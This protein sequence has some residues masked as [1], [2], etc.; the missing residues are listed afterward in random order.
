MSQKYDFA[1]GVEV[2]LEIMDEEYEKVIKALQK[3]QEWK[4][5]TRLPALE[6]RA[7]LIELKRSRL[8]QHMKAGVPFGIISA[9][10]G[11]T[12][13][14]LE[15]V[16]EKTKRVLTQAL[17]AWNNKRTVSLAGDIRSAGYVGVPVIGYGQNVIVSLSEPPAETG[18]IIK[19]QGTARIGFVSKK[20]HSFVVLPGKELYKREGFTKEDY[21]RLHEHLEKWAKKYNQWGYVVYRGDEGK[22]YLYGAN[23]NADYKAIP[24]KDLG[25]NV[26][27]AYIL[28]P[29][30]GRCSYEVMTTWDYISF[31]PD[32]FIGQDDEGN[33]VG[34]QKD[35]DKLPSGIQFYYTQLKKHASF[36][37]Q[38]TQTRKAFGLGIDKRAT[39]GEEYPLAMLD[40]DMFENACTTSYWS[41]MQLR[42]FRKVDEKILSM[43]EEKYQAGIKEAIY[44]LSGYEILPE[45]R[46]EEVIK[47]WEEIFSRMSVRR[48]RQC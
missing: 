36:Q 1:K 21:D 32:E 26:K 37:F 47:R 10:H 30:W 28:E 45:L 29:L 38:S 33:P 11:S 5:I 15:E 41:G 40:F 7:S 2:V 39:V 23:C 3:G 20:E 25:W 31:T 35:K 42:A 14:E 18:G 13:T 17:S 46:R 27:G 12:A 48:D 16:D 34:L 6:R 24:L 44:F 9:E 19:S 8:W 43:L 4:G 22:V